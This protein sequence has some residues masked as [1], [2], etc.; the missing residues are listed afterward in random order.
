MGCELSTVSGGR[1]VA[2]VTPAVQQ[3]HGNVQPIAVKHSETTESSSNSCSSSCAMASGDG[4]SREI[5][6]EVK[7]DPS[8]G[9]EEPYNGIQ[10]YAS[11]INT[12]R[13]SALSTRAGH[14]YIV[15]VP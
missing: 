7:A 10:V 14:I 4:A 3:P 2:K 12:A 13:F 11:S 6:R 9:K 8:V 15:G 5:E 1:T